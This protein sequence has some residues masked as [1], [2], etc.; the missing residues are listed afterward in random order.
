[1]RYQITSLKQA[2][3]LDLILDH[4]T[5]NPTWASNNPL[6]K[7]MK[8]NPVYLTL[9]C[10]IILSVSPKIV[11]DINFSGGRNVFR[12]NDH[13]KILIAQGGFRSIFE[14][15]QSQLQKAEDKEMLED[16]KLHYDVKNAERIFK[17][18][19]WSFGAS[20]LALIISILTFFFKK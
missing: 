8:D 9:L 12:I 10:N 18:Y 17:T 2:E 19:W 16:K 6:N 5:K 4:L 15:Q 1:M 14:K 20:I 7:E 13:G 11:I 3:D